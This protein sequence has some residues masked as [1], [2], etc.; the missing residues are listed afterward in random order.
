MF[1]EQLAQLGKKSNSEIRYGSVTGSKIGVMEGVI[2][3]GHYPECRVTFGRG[4]PHIV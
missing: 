1:Y 3:Y 2:V 4:G